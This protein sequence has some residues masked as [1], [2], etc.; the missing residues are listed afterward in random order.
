M[1][2]PFI[3]WNED[4]LHD[5]VHSAGRQIAGEPRVDEDDDYAYPDVTYFVD[6]VKR[7]KKWR[8]SVMHAD[9]TLHK[10][11]HRLWPTHHE[12]MLACEQHE[13]ERMR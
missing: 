6:L 1:T 3:I 7:S 8:S 12:A 11:G 2:D 9:R 13:R 4:D 10:V 5:V